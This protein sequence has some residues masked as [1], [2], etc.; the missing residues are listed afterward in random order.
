M[1]LECHLYSRRKNNHFHAEGEREKCNNIAI[2][3]GNDENDV[4]VMG[5]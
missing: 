5:V 2:N 3:N 1:G 4:L